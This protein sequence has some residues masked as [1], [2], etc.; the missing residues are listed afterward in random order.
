M[1]IVYTVYA[2]W[3]DVGTIIIKVVYIV[4]SSSCGDWPHT[5]SHNVIRTSHNNTVYGG[6]V[7]LAVILAVHENILYDY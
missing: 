3:F 6:S 4:Y 1:Y 2:Q 5:F 7:L